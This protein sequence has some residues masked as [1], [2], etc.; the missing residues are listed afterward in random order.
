MV[1]NLPAIVSAMYPPKSG[2]KKEVPVKARD[3]VSAVAL[4]TFKTL[5]QNKTRFALML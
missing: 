1:L 3:I 2:R 5:V 4:S